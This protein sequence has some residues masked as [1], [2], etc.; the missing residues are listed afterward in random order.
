MSWSNPPHSI[1]WVDDLNK[2]VPNIGTRFL[3]LNGGQ[4]LAIIGVDPVTAVFLYG[5]KNVFGML[6]VDSP[7]RYRFNITGEPSSYP[8]HVRR[9]VPFSPQLLQ[10]LVWSSTN[11]NKMSLLLKEIQMCSFQWCFLTVVV[12]YP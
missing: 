5:V 10:G 2:T 7:T 3:Y 8:V 1:T 4:Y 9:C 6:S 12:P 11:H